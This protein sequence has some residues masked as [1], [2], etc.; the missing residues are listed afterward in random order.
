V[1]ILDTEK[2]FHIYYP[3]PDGNYNIRSYSDYRVEELRNR[4]STPSWGLQNRSLEHTA[5]SFHSMER[6]MTNREIMPQSA[7]TL[8]SLHE[9]SKTSISACIVS[10]NE[11]DNIGDCIDSLAWCDE[12]VVVDSFSEDR[13]AEI[14]RTRGARVIENEWS[15]HVAQKNFALDAAKCEWVIALDCD[16]RVTPKLKE[17]ILDLLSAAQDVSGYSISRKIHYLGH[18]LEHGGWFPEW[19]LRLFRRDRGHWVGIDPHDTVRVQGRTGRISP[20]GRGANAAVILHYS[21]RSLSHQL[22]VLDRYTE[23]QGGELFRSGRR[24][25]PADLAIRPLWRFFRSYILRRGFLDGAAG[26]HMAVNNAYAAYMKYARLWEI[27]KGLVGLRSKKEVVPCLS[28]DQK[29]EKS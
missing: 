2:A 13:T 9:R 22:T 8:S 6:G 24:A 19:R 20:G 7:A 17:A 21:F 10:Y 25:N 18:W 11:E 4:K 16:E 3:Q 1:A 14:A 29:I 5:I 12:V 26:F 15:G 23:I 27:Q 28:E